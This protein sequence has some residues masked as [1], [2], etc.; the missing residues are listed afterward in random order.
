MAETFSWPEGTIYLW[1]GAGGSATVAYAASLR[2]SIDY[3]IENVRNLSG[4]YRNVSTGRRADVNVGM[5]YTV[6]NTWITKIAEAQT[7]VHMH[8]KQAVPGQGSAGHY[9]WSGSIDGWQS[10]GY[11]GGLYRTSINYHANEWSAY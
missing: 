4:T 6:D 7:A 8:I 11:D 1:T 9:M 10:Q 5:M 2:L 3:G